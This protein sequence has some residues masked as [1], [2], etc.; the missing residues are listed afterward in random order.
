MVVIITWIFLPKDL[1]NYLDSERRAETEEGDANKVIRYFAAKKETDHGFYFNYTTRPNGQ[2]EKLFWAD[3]IC[4][5]DYSYFGN[6]VAFDACYERNVYNIPLV[7]LV[8]MNH[9]RQ[10]IIFACALLENERTSSY[11]WLLNELLNCMGNKQPTSIVTDG[12]LAMRSAVQHVLPNAVHRLCIWH[13]EKNAS[14]EVK[15]ANFKEDFVKVMLAPVDVVVF[16]SLWTSLIEKYSLQK[17][18]WIEYMHNLN[19]IGF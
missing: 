1:Y 14:K 5:L 15:I 9:H 10:P 6:V 3:S 18:I 8:G 13:I 17:H 4:R 7:T 19:K 11:S 16:E 12:D 2:L